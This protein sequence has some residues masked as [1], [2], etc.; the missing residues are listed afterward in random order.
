MHLKLSSTKGSLGTLL[1]WNLLLLQSTEEGVRLANEI[2]YPVMIK[3]NY[4]VSIGS[5]W[6]FC[7]S[8]PKLSLYFLECFTEYWISQLVSLWFQ[9]NSRWWWTWNASCQWTVRV[10]ETVAGMKIKANWSTKWPTLEFQKII[11][12]SSCI[13]IF[14]RNVS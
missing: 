1:Y 10:C 14:D 7:L 5:R 4:F 11:I 8:F 9:G 12:T 2:G 6:S 3:V 13:Q